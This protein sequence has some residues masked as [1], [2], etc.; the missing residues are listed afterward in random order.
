MR[1]AD[2][3]EICPISIH[4]PTRGATFAIIS[5]VTGNNNFNPRTREGCDLIENLLKEESFKISIHAPTR[6]ATVQFPRREVRIIF[7]S[8]HPRGVRPLNIDVNALEYG[9]SI[10]APMRGATIET[11]TPEEIARLFQST[12]PRGVRR[13]S[14]LFFASFLDFN[15]RTHEGCDRP[16]VPAR[17]AGAFISIHA[18][19]RGATEGAIQRDV[20]GI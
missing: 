18:P 8:T 10:H 6:G 4:A 7:Q 17:I 12:H 19:T 11:D 1:H 3:F 20:T 14:T 16:F 13:L 2:G 15:P 9:I 5:K